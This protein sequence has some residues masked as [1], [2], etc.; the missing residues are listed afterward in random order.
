MTNLISHL[1][2]SRFLFPPVVVLVCLCP[3]VSLIASTAEQLVLLETEKI[4]VGFDRVRNGAI[5]SVVDKASGREFVAP[6][7]APLLYELQFSGRASQPMTLSEADAEAVAIS[8]EGQ[9]VVVSTTHRG[10][11]PVEVECRFRTELGSSL[12]FARITVHNRNGAGLLR[13]RFPALACSSQLGSSGDD[14]VLVYPRCD[15]CLVQSPATA[16]R[17]PE[18]SYPGPASMQFMALH[19]QTAGLYL[20]TYDAQAHTKR[21]GV[22][23]RGGAFRPAIWH[24]PPL[25][26]R[27]E[28][29]M[30]YDVVLGTF[31]GDWQTVADIYKAWAVKQLWCRRT[32]QER[33]AAG[34]VPNWLI[35]PSLNFKF[36]LRGEH[37]GERSANR[38]SL[39]VSQAEAWRKLLGSPVTMNLNGWEKR[40][41]WVTPDYFPPLGGTDAFR[42]MT[43]GLHAKGHRAMVLL[44][45]LKIRQAG[46]GDAGRYRG[47][48]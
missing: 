14:D 8:K 35:E 24:L 39:V 12:I 28:W 40:G 33:V 22:E 16:G 31:R 2:R 3:Y 34:D 1:I 30:P 19:D 42:A 26:P 10:D 21:F 11:L 47:N 27:A 23:S 15:G 9:S 32:L 4:R 20:A 29:R 17:I 46:N 38:L 6:K 25:A 43:A 48:G 41:F 18:L 37:A 5:V 44:S 45:G 13:V 36:S 7:A